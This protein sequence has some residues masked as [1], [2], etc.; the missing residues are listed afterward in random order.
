MYIYCMKYTFSALFILFSAIVFGQKYHKCKIYQYR[1]AY[2]ANKQLVGTQLFNKKGKISHEEYRQYLNYLDTSG[3]ISGLIKSDGSCGYEYDDTVLQVSIGIDTTAGFLDTLSTYFYYGD[4]RRLDR[5]ICIKHFKYVDSSISFSAAVDLRK[6]IHMDTLNY[7]YDRLGNMIE[8]IPGVES[9]YLH[10]FHKYD[11]ANRLVKDSVAGNNVVSTYS[12]SHSGYKV[13]VFK[14]GDLEPKVAVY[15]CDDN[16]RI[17]ESQ[18]AN[19]LI[20]RIYSKDGSLVR[21]MFY[22]KGE[23]ITTHIFVYK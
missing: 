22:A 6:S 7:L 2:S 23:L 17:V 9:A 12:Y 21:D 11:N 10:V 15:T 8:E 19:E 20:K 16:G 18:W 14:P 4:Y 1:G 5:K 13:F 3:D